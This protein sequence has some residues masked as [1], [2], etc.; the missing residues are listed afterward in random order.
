MF[1]SLRQLSDEQKRDLRMALA[2]MLAATVCYAPGITW[3]M[4][5]AVTGERTKAWGV[6]EI[7][8]M[9]PLFETR[10]LFLH[11][12]LGNPQ[13]P[14]F[15]YILVFVCYLPYLG[16]QMLTGGLAHPHAGHPY[17]FTDVTASVQMLLLIA[18]SVSVLMA[19]GT[20][21]AV[22]FLAK[23]LW[24]RAAG[25]CAALCMLSLYPMF[26]Y[27]KTSNVDMPAIFWTSIGLALFVRVLRDGLSPRRAVWL[28]L[29]AALAIAA[30]D[31][32][33]GT[34]LLLPIPILMAHF[35]ELNAQGRTSLRDRWL[36]PAIGL[37]VA[38]V[39][40]GFASGL[41]IYPRKFFW[42]LQ[43]VRAGNP[44]G[45][46]Y[47]EYEPTVA[48]YAALLRECLEH[49]TTFLG[50]PL[51]LLAA[52]GVLFCA[53]RD[54]RALWLLLPILALFVLVLMPV[55]FVQ[56]RFVFPWALV[57]ACFA[58]RAVA[59]AWQAGPRPVGWVVA[60]VAL[61]GGTYNLG[62]GADLA[63]T[64][65]RDSRYE[66]AAWLNA[67]MQ[68]GQRLEI[69]GEPM[70]MRHFPL[71]RDG[72]GLVVSE[73]KPQPGNGRLVG[74]FVMLTGDDLGR[75]RMCPRW[76]RDGLFDGSLGYHKAAEFQS[77]SYWPHSREFTVNPRV[78]FFQRRA[79]RDSAGARESNKLSP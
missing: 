8:P 42:H 6:D 30:K 44:S 73:V 37:G 12:P 16:L 21:V 66:A 19:G 70:R 20:L 46:F 47:F 71:L 59:A 14:M 29:W 76:V 10:N 49:L 39:V 7:A 67:Q 55:R 75:S 36:A 78:V 58:G 53:A 1:A 69:F 52:G 56:L 60:A 15:H 4:P 26:Y 24:G 17:G 72:V 25:V 32:S 28:G 40:Y 57:L 54:R 64:M 48:G 3:G 61:F 50:W 68:T 74:D 34:F 65:Y 51:L 2:L 31:A 27:G 62:R 63:R 35:R 41:F 13:Y 23:E 5:D 9:G 77:P 45:G 33:Y 38:A 11:G 22:Y 18:R 79:G 43:F